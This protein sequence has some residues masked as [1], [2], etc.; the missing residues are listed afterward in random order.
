MQDLFNYQ[1]KLLDSLDSKV[2]IKKM[3]NLIIFE[4]L[5]INQKYRFTNRVHL[6]NIFKYK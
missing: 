3:N 4:Y 6:I 2:E 1:N 5:Q